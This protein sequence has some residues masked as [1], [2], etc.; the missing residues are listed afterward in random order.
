MKTI[1]PAAVT[2]K[3]CAILLTVQQSWCEA[4]FY[5]NSLSDT[6][7][8]VSLDIA[9]RNIYGKTAKPAIM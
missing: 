7:I 3:C 6:A 4:K 9:E 2:A 1:L 5:H 8:T